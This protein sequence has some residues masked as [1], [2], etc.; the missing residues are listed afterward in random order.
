VLAAEF[1]ARLA[2]QLARLRAGL[3]AIGA[4]DVEAW[5]VVAHAAR[6]SAPRLR[7]R[8]VDHLLERDA[9]DTTSGIATAIDYPI[10]TTRRALEE[11]VAHQVARRRKVDQAD[12]WSLARWVV[13]AH[14]TAASGPVPANAGAPLSPLDPRTTSAF[15]GT[16]PAHAQE[17]LLDDVDGAER[18]L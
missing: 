13:A 18:D 5:R 10:G 15:A 7:R 17:H 4:D 8:I 16:V 12:E 9:P 14:A 2:G 11:L 3:L 6:S 1:P